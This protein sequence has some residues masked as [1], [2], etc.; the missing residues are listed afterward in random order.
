[1]RVK[2]TYEKLQNDLID[3]SIECGELYDV[4][5]KELQ[6]LRKMLLEKRL[7][8]LNRTL[9]RMK[10][11]L[12]LLG[13]RAFYD[14]RRAKGFKQFVPKDETENKATSTTKDKKRHRSIIGSQY[15]TAIPY[16]VGTKSTKRY[17]EN[18]KTRAIA[19]RKRSGR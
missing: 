9:D 18:T 5:I 11:E 12:Q 6:P 1:M 15:G 3:A 14:L 19:A 16:W 7:Q 4:Y 17:R 13:K 8:K 10:R 2:K